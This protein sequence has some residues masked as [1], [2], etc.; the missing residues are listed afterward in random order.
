L[1]MRDFL[2]C[3]SFCSQGTAFQVEYTQITARNYLQFAL[4]LEMV[5]WNIDQAL[6]TYL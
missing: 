2:R 1:C 5:V 3:I 4:I 6:E